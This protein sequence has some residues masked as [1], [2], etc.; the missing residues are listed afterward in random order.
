M[1]I[2]KLVNAS[3]AVEGGDASWSGKV[4][5][6]TNKQEAIISE[7]AQTRKE[8]KSFMAS[9]TEMK[10]MVDSIVKNMK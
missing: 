1:Y 3:D 8:L 4:K 10:N 5:V 2:H 9:Q 7:V 6:L